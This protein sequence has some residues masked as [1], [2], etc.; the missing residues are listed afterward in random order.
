MPRKDLLPQSESVR[1]ETTSQ[2]VGLFARNLHELGAAACEAKQKRF[3]TKVFWVNNRHINYTNICQGSC[4][5][6]RFRRRP[7]DSD[8]Y[9]LTVEQLLETVADAVAR[10]V[11]E[12]HLVGG[13]NASLDLDYYVSLIRTLRKNFNDLFIKAFTAVE[14]DFISQRS[15]QSLAVV[16]AHL[17]EAGLDCLAGGGAEIFADRVRREVCPTKLDAD[18]WLEIHRTAHRLGLASNATMLF[19]HMETLSE[20][21]DHLLRLRNLQD[22]TNGFLSFL[23]LPVVDFKDR[24]LDGL[25]ALKTLAVSR[26]VLDNFPHI[27]VFWPL[28][29]LKLAQLGLSYGADDLD[30]TV[31]QYKIVESDHSENVITP[32]TVQQV[33]RQAGFEPVER[34]GDYYI[35]A[36]SG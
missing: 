11:C 8:A 25:S 24:A 7:T 15:D 2:I 5:F 33:I 12:V 1:L 31:G 13:L 30:G 34:R 29:T 23:P 26:L 35:P 27:K 6:C 22:E 20:R 4:A 18:R 3:G 36:N 17:Q 21:A 9:S 32:E 10:G 28:W 16:L 14:I 19:G